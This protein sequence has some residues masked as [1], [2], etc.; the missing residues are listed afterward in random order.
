M[1]EMQRLEKQKSQSGQAVVEY[2]LLLVIAVALILG[3]ANQVYR[4]FGKWV[5]NEMGPYLECL[6][7]VG[8][9]PALGGQVTGECVNPFGPGNSDDP[10]NPNKR[11]RPGS[12]NEVAGRER[13]G[14]GGSGSA[15][16]S[17]GGGRAGRNRGF[18]VGGQGSA[19][20][21]GSGSGTG[22]IVEPLPQSS[23]FRLRSNNSS[24]VPQAA[25]SGVNAITAEAR[26]RVNRPKTQEERVF[27][28]GQLDMAENGQKTKRLIVS[29]PERKPTAEDDS[30]EWNFG[31]YIKF[32]LIL[33]I[34]IAIVLF[35]AGQVSSITKSMEK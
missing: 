16:T 22:Q 3:L 19:D 21:A 4:P 35:V 31:Q 1:K 6:L 32:A 13:S 33:A 34:I 10:N 18:A 24:N 29:P 28:A 11:R 30:I 8:E 7:D 15:A 9:L 14:G 2:V 25:G 5:E 20:G 12:G 23:F 17:G 27:S 26:G